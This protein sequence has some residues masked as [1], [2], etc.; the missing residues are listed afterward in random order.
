[1]SSIA[2]ITI[3]V[4]DNDSDLEAAL[5]VALEEAGADQVERCGQKPSWAAASLAPDVVVIGADANLRRSLDQLTRARLD[6]PAAHL[7]MA[8]VLWGGEMQLRCILGGAGGFIER[9]A[10]PRCLRWALEECIRGRAHITPGLAGQILRA[11]KG[12]GGVELKPLEYRIL[13]RMSTGEM[14]SKT[15]ALAGISEDDVAHC[16]AA[17]IEK[18]DASRR[19]GTPWQAY[20][21][22]FECA[23]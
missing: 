3:A 16:V 9:H 8:S 2:Q 1:M 11:V 23:Q 12:P 5:C 19:H 4:I 20:V 15:A 17:V 13:S 18:L 7:L 22:S 21:G 10:T 6:F 14:A